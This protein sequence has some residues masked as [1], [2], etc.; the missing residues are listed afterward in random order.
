MRKNS[1]KRQSKTTVFID[2]SNFHHTCNQM[3]IEPDYRA[4]RNSLV[5]HQENYELRMYIGVFSPPSSLQLA[6][7][8]ELKKLGYEIFQL[9]LVKRKKAQY[10]VVGDDMKL[11]IDMIK[12]VLT[13]KLRSGDRIVLVTG[14]GD[15]FPV[16]EQVKQAAE[17]DITLVSAKYSPFLEPF[18]DRF[19]DLEDL[20]DDIRKYKRWYAA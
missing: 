2:G 15:Y 10:K 20:K 16:L 11:G 6:L 3:N 17:I 5:S 1:V 13:N 9:P 18:I 12:Q 8:Y 14:D 19:V 7:N 4:F